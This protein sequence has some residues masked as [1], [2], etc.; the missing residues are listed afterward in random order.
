MSFIKTAFTAKLWYSQEFLLFCPPP[1]S[2]TKADCPTNTFPWKLQVAHPFCSTLQLI[3]TQLF[4]HPSSLLINNN[5]AA[6]S[7][8]QG[9]FELLGCHRN[10]C[11]PPWVS[12][13]SLSA[14]RPSF[15]PS[16]CTIK[17]G[18]DEHNVS[19]PPVNHSRTSITQL[20]RGDYLHESFNLIS[21]YLR[22]MS[23]EMHS[24]VR[25]WKKKYSS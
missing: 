8:K 16:H 20:P 24:D 15:A 7:P 2:Q 13:H 3:C 5:G 17:I 14:V 23:Q 21:V 1:V 4:V 6:V 9:Q 12:I 19:H 25:D 10:C 18:A 22:Q 11:W